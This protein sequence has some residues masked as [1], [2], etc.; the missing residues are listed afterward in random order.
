[1][2]LEQPK[3]ADPSAA[4]NP[5]RT[6]QSSICFQGSTICRCAVR[7]LLRKLHLSVAAQFRL[8]LFK[9]QPYAYLLEQ[10]Q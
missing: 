7:Y 3:G 9:S 8:I 2:N 4:E 5:G 10:K 6:S 1:M